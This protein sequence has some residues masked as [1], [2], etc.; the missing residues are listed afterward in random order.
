MVHSWSKIH[1]CWLKKRDSKLTIGVNFTAENTPRTQQHG[2]GSSDHVSAVVCCNTN[3]VNVR[4]LWTDAACCWHFST[5]AILDGSLSSP[6]CIYAS[7][8]T[9][10]L[11][12]LERASAIFLLKDV[13][14]NGR[15]VIPLRN[16]CLFLW[17]SFVNIEKM[18]FQ[19]RSP[20]LGVSENVHNKYLFL[21]LF[22]FLCMKL[23]KWL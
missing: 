16:L 7:V 20:K 13:V 8:G 6:Q 10:C 4:N 17:H 18:H 12:P 1:A 11:L 2:A 9:H 14:K 21:L 23:Y 22:S 3:S 15:L 5:A 19:Y